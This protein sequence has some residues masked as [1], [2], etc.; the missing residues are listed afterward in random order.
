MK[1]INLAAMSAPHTHFL[2]VNNTFVCV[3]E[4]VTLALEKCINAKT[5]IKSKSSTKA[6]TSADTIHQ[7]ASG[8]Y[9]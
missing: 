8:A 2:P 1:E 7:I 4:L 3:P 6:V 5:R 9:C